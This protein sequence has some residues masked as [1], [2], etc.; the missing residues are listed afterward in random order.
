MIL[1]ITKAKKGRHIIEIRMKVRMSEDPHPRLRCWL[2]WEGG[3]WDSGLEVCSGG[4][5]ELR[6]SLEKWWEAYILYF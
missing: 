6:S 3:G 4:R 2:G 5:L 1:N